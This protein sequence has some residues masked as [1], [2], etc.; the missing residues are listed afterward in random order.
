MTVAGALRWAQEQL[1]QTAGGDASTDARLFVC[2]AMKTER[3]R[4]LLRLGETLR[5]EQE[6][7]L[8]DM[9]CRRNARI[10]AQHIVGNAQFLGNTFLCDERALIPRFDTEILAQEAVRRIRVEGLRDALDLCTGSGCIAVTIAQ[11]GISTTAV[12]CSGA[13]LALAGE[14][15]R[16]L[17]VQVRFFQ[18]D[19]FG[20][21]PPGSVFDMIVSNPPYIPSADID[22]LDPEVRDH[23]PRIALD[24]GG[25]GLLF[26][27]RIAREGAAFLRPGGRMML[28]MGEG[29]S[30]DVRA[31]FAEHYREI[32]VIQDLRGIDRVITAIRR[33]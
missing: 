3:N 6:A 2:A 9:V 1:A 23:E 32:E 26:Y 18:G 28:E 33:R 12:D 8:R 21:L 14:N 15:A 11:A 27:R 25:D 20:A 7:A 31:L 22:S 24:G 19:L 4:I 13:A 5:D 30:P 17:G 29:Q 16:R 10:P